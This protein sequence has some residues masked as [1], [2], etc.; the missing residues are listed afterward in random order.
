MTYFRFQL[1]L[2]SQFVDSKTSYFGN[3]A[4]IVKQYSEKCG[5]EALIPALAHRSVSGDGFFDFYLVFVSL[6]LS[7]YGKFLFVCFFNFHAAL[8]LNH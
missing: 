4:I 8:Q 1:F 2:V 3:H 7:N 5:T 6:L